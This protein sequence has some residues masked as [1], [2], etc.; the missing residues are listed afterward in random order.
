MA[1]WGTIVFLD[2]L[3][4]GWMPPWYVTGI[5]VILSFSVMLLGLHHWNH[6]DFATMN[7]SVDAASA[8]EELWLSD[9]YA[10]HDTSTSTRRGQ[11]LPFSVLLGVTLAPLLKSTSPDIRNSVLM[12]LSICVG[13]LGCGYLALA[14]IRHLIIRLR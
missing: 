10:P 5:T 6:W 4:T 1:G 11:L 8:D 2:L 7:W 12:V 13:T 9:D 14:Y 3:R